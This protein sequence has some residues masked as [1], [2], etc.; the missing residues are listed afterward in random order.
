MEHFPH[1][2]CLYFEGNAVVSLDGLQLNRELVSLYMHENCIRKMEHL[3]TLRNLKILNLADNCIERI[4][5]LEGLQLDTLYLARNRIGWNGIE[6]LKGLLECP[7][8]TCIDLQKNNIEDAAVL[9]EIFEKMPELKVLYLLDNKFAK[10]IK[11]YRKTMTVKL[12]KLSY[13]DDR[14]VFVEDRRHAEA[15][16]RGGIEEERKERETIKQENN[17]RD[18]KNR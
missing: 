2:K 7:S 4:E 10:G 18:E 11:N 16:A 6:D 5:G 9:P 1:L 8:L 15:F 14:P 3:S 17:A 12:P 13:L